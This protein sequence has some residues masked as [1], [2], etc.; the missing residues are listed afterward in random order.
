METVI[1]AIHTS[2]GGKRSV[3]ISHAADYTVGN[4]RIYC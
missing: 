2:S 4:S 3:C 1:H